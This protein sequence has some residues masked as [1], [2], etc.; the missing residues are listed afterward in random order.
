MSETFDQNYRGPE[1]TSAYG[2]YFGDLYNTNYGKKAKKKSQAV[3]G[4]GG[5]TFSSG[6]GGGPRES[7]AESGA[8]WE[9]ESWEENDG[10]GGDWGSD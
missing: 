5:E 1:D 9:D 8:P 2:E 4:P 3:P 6:G 10:G 7:A